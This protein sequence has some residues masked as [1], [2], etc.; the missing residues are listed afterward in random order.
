[1]KQRPVNHRIKSDLLQMNDLQAALEESSIPGMLDVTRRGFLVAPQR[2]IR[3][4]TFSYAG[5]RTHATLAV[6][7]SSIAL[8][9]TLLCILAALL[10]E[11]LRGTVIAED[12]LRGD[13]CSVHFQDQLR[14]PKPSS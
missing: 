12:I 4:R 7:L 11:I 9:A 10:P 1:V 5:V 3:K 6:L 8:Y 2:K 14:L 13:P